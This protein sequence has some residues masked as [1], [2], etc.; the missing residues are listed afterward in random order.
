MLQRSGKDHSHGKQQG[1][2]GCSQ[3]ET[4][5]PQKES[6]PSVKAKERSK[7]LGREQEKEQEKEQI[8]RQLEQGVLEAAASD[9]RYSHLLNKEEKA[10]VKDVIR[11]FLS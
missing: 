9:S 5:K 3:G 4:G 1:S 2:N 8:A 7:E 6:A 10:I 11:E